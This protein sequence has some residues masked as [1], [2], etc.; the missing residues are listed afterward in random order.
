[1]QIIWD[2]EQSEYFEF[3]CKFQNKSIKAV[4]LQNEYFPFLQQKLATKTV[5]EEARNQIENPLKL[6]S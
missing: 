3:L 4:I 2:C 1:M 6:K 5:M